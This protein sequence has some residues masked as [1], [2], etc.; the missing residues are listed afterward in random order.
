MPC[1]LLWWRV[2]LN[3]FRARRSEVSSV[4]SCMFLYL[5]V[6]CVFVFILDN[7][8]KL[9]NKLLQ[10]CCRLRS[11]WPLTA[12]FLHL[13][14]NTVRW[15][16]DEYQKYKLLLKASDVC[17]SPASGI[18]ASRDGCFDMMCVITLLICSSSPPC[19]D[20]SIRERPVGKHPAL[21][22]SGAQVLQPD[23]CSEK[24]S[25]W[26]LALLTEIKPFHLLVLRAGVVVRI[27][28]EERVWINAVRRQ[29]AIGPWKMLMHHWVL[30]PVFKGSSWY[31][32]MN[33][34]VPDLK[35]VLWL[36]T[37]KEP[38]L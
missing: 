27:R 16:T 10:S 19:A 32:P 3:R 6:C 35:P 7:L 34:F 24:V 23:P 14:L 25:L 22:P 21:W 20:T 18:K 2:P 4:T 12:A 33:S 8:F 5:F 13:L 31:L 38:M 11:G 29:T 9:L 26:C 36:Q 30:F 17:P 37:L 1:V 28:D 15:L